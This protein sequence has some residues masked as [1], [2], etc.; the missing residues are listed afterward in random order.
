MRNLVKFTFIALLSLSS[1]AFAA[2]GKKVIN[3]YDFSF[4][5]P[6]G[7]YDQGQLRRGLEVYTQVCS[8]CHGMKLVSFRSLEDLGYDEK[9]INDYASNYEV[10]D[11]TLDDFRP[12]GKNDYFPKSMLSNAP[13]LSLM[14][15]ARKGGPDYIAS[16]LTGYTGE[17]RESA[18]YVLYENTAYGGYLNMAPPLYGDDIIF[19]D[20][21]PTDLENT[22]KDVAAFLMWTAEPKLEARKSSGAT[23][24]FL[25]TLL[26]ALLYLTK[27]QIW[28]TKKD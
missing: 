12:A 17:E 18:G 19:E 26:T 13:D 15:K 25:L 4:D 2:E 3:D 28:H 14:A 11:S 1:V 7:T 27:K 20:G 23:A 9:E 8:A 10:F 6:F 22:S 5:G 21:S 24:I 16:L